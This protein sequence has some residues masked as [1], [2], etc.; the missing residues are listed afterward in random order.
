MA[1]TGISATDVKQAAAELAAMR[2]SL[3]KWMKYRA[4]NDQVLSG[5][6]TKIRKPLGYGQRVIS[7]SRDTALE[8]DMADKLTALLEV[9]M[10]DA[11]LPDSNLSNNPDAAMQLAQ[12]A[13]T[14]ESTSLAQP[15]A[16]SGVLTSHPWLW[17]VLIVG[18]LVLITTTAIRSA[19]DVAA[20][21][22]QDAC[23]EAGAC[24]DSGLW[25]KIGGIAIAAYV[26]WNMLGLKEMVEKHKRRVSE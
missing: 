20:Q 10:P 15:T 6:I 9:V 26:A 22:E 17:P 19:A 18:G 1:S 16:T 2:A 7:G 13:I 21:R 14:G 12:I 24:T 5:T 8:Q 3:R 11:Q 4:L 25:L 23:I